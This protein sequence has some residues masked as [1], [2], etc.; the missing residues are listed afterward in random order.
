[1]GVFPPTVY[2]PLQR[3][4]SEEL[5][6]RTETEAEAMEGCSL[7]TCFQPCL[8][9]LSDHTFLYPIVMVLVVC[10]E[11]F[12]IKSTFVSDPGGMFIDDLIETSQLSFLLQRWVK[13][14]IK[15]TMICCAENILY[16]LSLQSKN[17]QFLKAYC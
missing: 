10:V 15:L 12:Y 13:L 14:I 5:Q 2:S 3:E 16:N 6:E 11:C 17:H 7:R 9:Y 4:L 8:N 1:M